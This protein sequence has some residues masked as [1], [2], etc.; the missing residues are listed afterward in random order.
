MRRPTC[1]K[2]RIEVRNSFCGRLKTKMNFNPFT[3]SF[4][5]STT[6]GQVL[7]LALDIVN[8]VKK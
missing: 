2:L 6:W 5:P 8:G 1:G 3:A 4:V 7:C